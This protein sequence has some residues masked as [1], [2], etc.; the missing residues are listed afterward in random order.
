MAIAR[1]KENVSMLR[2]HAKKGASRSGGADKKLLEIFSL[3]KFLLVVSLVF[4][5]LVVYGS[6]S[7]VQTVLDVPVSQVDV[8][9][10]FRYLTE[11]DV[12]RVIGNYVNNDFVRVDLN[13]LRNEFLALPWVYQANIRRKLPNGLQVTLKEQKPVAYWNKD[14][15]INEEGETF[16]PAHLPIIDGLPHL[17]GKNHASVLLLYRQLVEQLPA[18]QQPVRRVVV[19]D[20]NLARVE[21]AS[22]AILIFDASDLLEK[23]QIWK[24]I[25]SDDLGNRLSEVEYVDLRYS[26]GAAVKWRSADNSHPEKDWG[27][28]VHGK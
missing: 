1:N 15:L 7:A 10:K 11:E 18:V 25:S 23:M 20:S 14:G 3:T 26:N 22:G 16:F 27:S 28:R 8:E 2:P 19:N 17:S 4:L 5:V 6:F 13:K 24:T 9:G 12:N 21:I